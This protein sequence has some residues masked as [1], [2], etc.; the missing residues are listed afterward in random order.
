MIHHYQGSQV[1]RVTLFSS[2]CPILKILPDL[3]LNDSVFILYVPYFGLFLLDFEEEDLGTLFMIVTCRDR[4]NNFEF[5]CLFIFW[6]QLYYSLS[7]NCIKKKFLII[8]SQ[9]T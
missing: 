8:S 2:K 4:V 6:T 3:F 9:I 1:P 5:S 7:F